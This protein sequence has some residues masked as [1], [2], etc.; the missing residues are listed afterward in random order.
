MNAVPAIWRIV[1]EA[2]DQHGIRGNPMPKNNSVVPSWSYSA[3]KDEIKIVESDYANWE[4][5]WNG[6]V[7][8]HSDHPANLIRWAYA[9]H[10]IDF[11]KVITLS[12]DLGIPTCFSVD[13]D[14]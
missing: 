5:F 14:R 3:S 1:D 8:A 6:Q 13:K 10:I 12:H 11:T 2:C 9:K 4:L 7:V